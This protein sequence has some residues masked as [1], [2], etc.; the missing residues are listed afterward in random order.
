MVLHTNLGETGPGFARNTGM[1][2]AMGATAQK[3]LEPG[4]TGTAETD[5]RPSGKARFKD[6]IINVKSASEYIEKGVSIRV[7]SVG[8]F[9]IEVEESQA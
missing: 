7:V 4:D 6:R 5:L 3:A 1:L 9:V 8:R 2:G